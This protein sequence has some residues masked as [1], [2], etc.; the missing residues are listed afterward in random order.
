MS[1]IIDPNTGN[2]S[3]IDLAAGGAFGAGELDLT[4]SP[5]DKK[6]AAMDFKDSRELME[7]QDIIKDVLSGDPEAAKSEK[8]RYLN[9]NQIKTAIEWLMTN[10]FDEQMQSLLLSNPWLLT[11]KN[12][13][14]TP[15]EFLSHK[16]IGAMADSV[17]LP[18]RKMFIEYFD[19]LK[20]YRSAVLNPAIGS[21][22]M[23]PVSSP[24]QV[25]EE[26]YIEIKQDGYTL[27]FSLDDKVYA[28]G[29]AV[30][31]RDLKED[32]DFPASIN[33]IVMMI[34]NVEKTNLFNDAFDI[35]SYNELISYFKKVDPNIYK[36]WRIYTQR[37]H[38]VPVCEGG[39]NDKSNIVKLP[40]YFHMLAHYL[41]GKEAE[42]K[43]DKLSMYRNYKAVCFAL[44]EHTVPKD[45]VDVHEKLKI[46]VESIDKKNELDKQLIWAT[47]GVKTVHIFESQLQDYPGFHRGRTFRSPASK[48]W[49]N[50][51]GKNYYFEKD[52]VE[53][54]LKEGYKLGMFKTE[55]MK[56]AV[57]RGATVS[58]STL[59]T[60]WMSKDG[61]SKAVKKDE[62][63]EHLKNGWSLGHCFKSSF[64]K[65]SKSAVHKGL[66]IKYVDKDKLEDF[67]KE[68]WSLG[69]GRNL[70]CK[71]Q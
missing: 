33:Y 63:E 45:V 42:A 8:Y 35:K 69:M 47:D 34:Y 7:L 14:P 5:T 40:Y 65:G 13:P 56:A 11:F 70:K 43:G 58:F 28:N 61:V 49:M 38:I 9:F 20:P 1:S 67:F 10:N 30:L 6:M 71:L 41:R 16:Y 59:G 19:P 29:K 55:R 2:Y 68:G 4:K 46:I 52:N 3:K 17:W 36:E 26:D 22:K 57:A 15:D 62:V 23:Q 51:D 39:A 44:K 12:K 21:G 50:K 48:K 31:A 60:K 66:E 64:K 24:I 18:V 53:Q 37:H 25:G 27:E 54:K 32:D